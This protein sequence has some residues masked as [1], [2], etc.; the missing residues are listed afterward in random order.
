MG[1]P[2][3]GLPYLGIVERFSCDDPCLWD[4]QSDLVPNLY[5]NPTDPPFLQK[6]INLSQSHLI[7]DILGP[8]IDLIFQPNVLFNR[9]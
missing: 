6:K 5:L 1:I 4:F 8:K 7:P 2:I 3:P 9:F